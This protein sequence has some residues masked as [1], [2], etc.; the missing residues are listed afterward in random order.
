M[1][2]TVLVALITA[3][4]GIIGTVIKTVLEKKK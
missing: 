2:D 3:A 1:S 4:S